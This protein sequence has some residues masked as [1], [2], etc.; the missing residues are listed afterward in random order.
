VTIRF[1]AR[2]T[3]SFLAAALVCAAAGCKGD[4]ADESP[5][6]TAPAP[7]SGDD[8]EGDAEDAL[9]P[10]PPTADDLAEYTSDLEGDGP[11][12]ATLETSMGTIRCRLF[13][14]EAPMTVANFV[15][16]ARGKKAWR[17][18]ATGEV[19]TDP[20]YDGTIFHRVIP[21]FMIQGGDPLGEGRGGPGYRFA[22][23]VSDDVRHDEPG[24][25]SMANAGPDTNGSQ[26]FITEAPQPRLDGGYSVFGQCDDVDVVKEIARVEK[27]E[28]GSSKPKEDVVL[29]K[30]T[31]SRG[32]G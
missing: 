16:L 17:H 10:Q 27:V 1:N 23:E 7:E 18:P 15:G 26:F 22:S 12:T 21:E 6:Q 20:L 14:D 4:S 24:T 31:I 30:V 29:E 2:S 13:E 5:E 25:L 8:D 3:L 11:L 28:S 9:A 32:D 19:T